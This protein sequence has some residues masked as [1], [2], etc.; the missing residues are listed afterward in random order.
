MHHQ[1]TKISGQ[2]TPAEHSSILLHL[3]YF[4]KHPEWLVKSGKKVQ[5][6][7]ISYTVQ[8]FY[9]LAEQFYISFFNSD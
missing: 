5:V 2:P 9:M 1:D 6:G 4:Q 7:S 8:S 3:S